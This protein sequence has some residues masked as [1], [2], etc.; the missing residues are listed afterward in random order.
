[1]SRNANTDPTPPDER[2]ELPARPHD[3]IEPDP[4]EPV[5]LPPDTGPQPASP[6]GEPNLP[7]SANPANWVEH[8]D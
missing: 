4:M 6:A 2:P 5:T 7:P 1:M 8:E 3:P